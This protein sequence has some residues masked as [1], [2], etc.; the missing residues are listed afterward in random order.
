MERAAQALELAILVLICKRLKDPGT[1]SDRAMHLVEDMAAIAALAASAAGLMGRGT[2]RI[3]SAGSNEIASLAVSLNVSPSIFSDAALEMGQAA[4]DSIIE[5]ICN[6]AA[7][8]LVS[9]QGELLPIRDAY[10]ALI[11][12]AATAI[13]QGRESYASAIDRTVRT[14][15]R[16]GVRVRYPSGATRELYS[17]VSMNVMDAYR[18]A[19]HEARMEVGR[20]AGCDGVEISAHGM[21][22][23]DHLPY[24]GQQYSDKDFEKIQESLKRPIGQGYNCRHIIYPIILGVSKPAHSASALDE[25]ARRSRRTVTVGGRDMTAYEFS[26]R[27]RSEET[28]I[29]KLR[30]ERLLMQEAGQSTAETDAA[31][32]RMLEVYRAESSQAGVETR[33]ERTRA[34]TMR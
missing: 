8:W 29:R 30:A 24:Q 20:A 31:I 4:A 32:D 12:D 6:T 7:M 18:S 10:V 2:R 22:A 27:Q 25:Y 13:A 11:N 3:F 26:Q 21:C 17:A 5:A 15:A 34:Y 14:L 23:E 9:P 19:M 28:A 33:Y 1:E 16:T